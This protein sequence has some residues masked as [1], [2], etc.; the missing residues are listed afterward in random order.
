MKKKMLLILLSAILVAALSFGSISFA[1]TSVTATVFTGKA[2]IN[3][4]VID[5]EHMEYP[6]LV[7]RDTTYLP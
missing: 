7:Y 2:E 6:L 5:T 4:Q 1:A 3:N